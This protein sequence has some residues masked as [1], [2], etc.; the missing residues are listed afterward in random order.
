M[1]AA[2]FT[3][4]KKAA[5]ASPP[6]TPPPERRDT[7]DEQPRR[8][9]F[10]TAEALPVGFGLNG[11]SF[12][13]R[14]KAVRRLSEERD[15]SQAVSAIS[16][17]AMSHLDILMAKPAGGEVPLVRRYDHVFLLLPSCSSTC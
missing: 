11:Q 3:R 13:S 1:V 7:T 5:E 17:P 4:K 10:S 12:A 16:K 14:P 2:P 6:A 15:T 9:S 8:V